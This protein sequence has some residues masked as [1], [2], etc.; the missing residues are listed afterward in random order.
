VRARL[1]AGAPIDALVTARVAA[2]LR[3][4]DPRALWGEAP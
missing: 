2:A 1:R 3:Q 4:V